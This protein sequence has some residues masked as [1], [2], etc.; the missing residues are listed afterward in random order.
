MTHAWRE[1]IPT[2]T[3]VQRRVDR[4]AIGA[5]SLEPISARAPRSDRAGPE[6]GRWFSICPAARMNSFCMRWTRNGSSPRTR[7]SMGPAN[8]SIVKVISVSGTGSSGRGSAPRRPG[9]ASEQI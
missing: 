5:P 8:R 4:R 3:G 1:I 7:Q 6:V 9:M 2:Q